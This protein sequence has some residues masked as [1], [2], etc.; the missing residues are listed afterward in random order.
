MRAG[1]LEQVG[2]P[3]EVFDRPANRFVAEFIGTPRINILEGVVTIANG[4]PALHVG[5]AVLPLET[6]PQ[7][8]AQ[9]TPLALGIRP[10]ALSLAEPGAPG[11]LSGLVQEAE[12]TGPETLYHIKTPGGELRVMTRQDASPGDRV[13]IRFDP[14]AMVFFGPEGR[15][16]DKKGSA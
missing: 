12:P 7:G 6:A 15:R 2:T 8:L 1:R 9:G 5:E 3:L 13:G 16:L 4:H 11:T 14:A 10:R